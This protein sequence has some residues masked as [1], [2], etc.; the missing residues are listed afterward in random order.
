MKKL[1]VIAIAALL[2]ASIAQPAEARHWHGGGG[3]FLL[4][5]GVGL[6][7]PP[8]IHA[9]PPPVV[10]Q[11][12]YPAPPPE[13]YSPYQPPVERVWVPG[14]WTKRWNPY[15]R[16]WEKFWVPGHWSENTLP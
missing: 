4:G 11:P 1:I 10:Y 7:V 2:L 15:Y 13:A 5:L 9:A 16:V 6:L 14:Y 3:A 12:Y 8:L